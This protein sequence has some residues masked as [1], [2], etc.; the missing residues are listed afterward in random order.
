[1]I[2]KYLQGEYHFVLLSLFFCLHG[3]NEFYTLISIKDLLLICICLLSGSI[4]LFLVLKKIFRSK[5]RAA[6]LLSYLLFCFLFFGFLQDNIAKLKHIAFFSGPSFLLPF[7]LIL[8]VV[9]YRIS[10][11]ERSLS[12]CTAY[13]N[14]LFAILVS[15]EVA[16]LLYHNSDGKTGKVND[17]SEFILSDTSRKPPVYVLV[18][19]EYAGDTTLKKFYN[20]ENKE[21][22]QNL[23]D[24]GFFIADSSTSNYLLTLHSIAS[25]FNMSYLPDDVSHLERNE[26]GYKKALR[27]IKYNRVT[28]T[29]SLLGYKI[30]NYSTFDFKQSPAT[31]RNEFWGGNQRLLTSQMMHGRLKKYIPS[32]LKWGL[33]QKIFNRKLKEEHYQNIDFQIKSSVHYAASHPEETVFAYLHLNLPHRPFLFD[34]TGNRILDL[35]KITSDNYQ[36]AY[37]WNLLQANRITIQ[38]VQQLLT[39]Y[40]NNVVIL[41]ISDH[42]TRPSFEDSNKDRRF[43]NLN[44]VYLPDKN[45]GQWYRG[46]SNVNQ[47]RILF[48]TL[49]NGKEKN[50]KDSCHPIKFDLSVLK[51]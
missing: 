18:L 35:Y 21:F 47:F 45:Y 50:L 9:I 28:E 27:M 17:I 14:T 36:Q 20:F 44:A 8:F 12:V 29:F 22:R 32:I 15:F 19:D 16:I 30:L 25:M 4:L 43:D 37:L 31:L 49:F 39:I 46:V 38:W 42:G 6:V 26:F 2:R 7:L 40:N 24:H 23:T 13:L 1:M 10:K 51:D 11:V 34:S 5:K 3:Y 41:I 48:N 33:L